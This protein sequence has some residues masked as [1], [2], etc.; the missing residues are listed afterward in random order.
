MYY[1]A[2]KKELSEEEL[3]IKRWGNIENW[4]T[5]QLFIDDQHYLTQVSNGTTNLFRL[6]GN[7]LRDVAR[8]LNDIP[9][10][11]LHKLNPELRF[12]HMISQFA[13]ML[14]EKSALIP[15][16]LQNKRGEV[17]I[18]WIPA[19]FNESVKEFIAR[20]HLFVRLY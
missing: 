13:H 7:V 8:F 20:Y 3:F 9:S 11:L 1:P 18:R 5:F 14:M 4:Q 19:L 12:M 10:S 6:S 2:S 16:V 17:I 15:Q